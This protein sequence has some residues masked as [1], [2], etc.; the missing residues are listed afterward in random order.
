MQAVI[1]PSLPLSRV[2]RAW[3]PPRRCWPPRR[4]RRAT[5][6]GG[7]DHQTLQRI[8]ALGGRPAPDWRPPARVEIEAGRGPAPAPAPCERIEPYLPPGALAWGRS[9]IGLRCARGPT[10]M[11]L[12]V[13]VKVFAPAWVLT[14]P[15]PAGSTLQPS[16][17]SRP[18]S[19]GGR[20]DAGGEAA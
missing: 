12:P 4:R 13:T 11:S 6:D 8:Q 18:R 15:L 5:A 7:L 2:Q 20:R 10:G 17:C 14:A 9:R 16:T 3:A 19:L 1:K